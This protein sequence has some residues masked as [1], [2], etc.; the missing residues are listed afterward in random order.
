MV[1]RK[2]YVS[3]N[4]EKNSSCSV[5]DPV[6]FNPDTNANTDPDSDASLIEK[7]KVWKISKNSKNVL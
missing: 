5:A 4:F 2:T 7:M 6:K 3:E 1:K